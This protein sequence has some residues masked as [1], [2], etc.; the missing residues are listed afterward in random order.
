MRGIL[1]ALP[2]L[3]I[4]ALLF[5]SAD[6]IFSRVLSNPL[7]WI[8][9]ASAGEIVARVLV[10]SLLAYVLAGLSIH[11]I[12]QP[13]AFKGYREHKVRAA[14]S[15]EALVV[16]A[17]IDLLFAVFVAV[18]LRY[19]F[20]GEEA[21]KT[22]G[23][24]YA[25]YARRGFGQLIVVAILTLFLFLGLSLLSM[26]NSRRLGRT[27]SLLGSI[28]ILLTSV[29]L[30]SALQ[31]LL[32]YEDAYGFTRL[33]TY[34]HVFIF[35]L[36]GLLVGTLALQWLKRLRAFALLSLAASLAFILF[37]NVLGVD[38]FVAERNLD[39]AVAGRELDMFYLV[40][41]SADAVPVLV[42][43]AGELPP[44]SRAVLYRM[45]ACPFWN[46]TRGEEGWQSF[47]FSRQRARRS[48]S[49]LPAADCSQSPFAP[50]H[51]PEIPPPDAESKPIAPP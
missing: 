31:R 12:N 44:E 6:P 16:V 11:A 33:R 48:L 2:A 29:I 4:F 51:F 10:V 28:W 15:T 8:E 3:V 13:G 41:L 42:A 37:L 21:V 38:A 18:Q 49:S 19:F 50:Q 45:L 26:P 46:V 23:F 20:A 1:L 30:V 9:P 39:R 24:T 47:H 36:A 5:A 14:G 43:R 25:E 27:F 40:E 7:D 17:G 35:C 22:L 34:T 32:L